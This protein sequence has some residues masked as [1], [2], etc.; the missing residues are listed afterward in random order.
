MVSGNF[1]QQQCTYLEWVR[2][3]RVGQFAESGC[4]VFAAVINVS[5]H[6]GRRDDQ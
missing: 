4:R 6:E 2:Q 5:D 3:G 1:Q